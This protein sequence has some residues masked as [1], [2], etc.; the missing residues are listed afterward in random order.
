[1]AHFSKIKNNKVV[2]LIVIAN[3]DCGGGNF[4]DSEPIGQEFIASLSKSDPRLEGTWVQTSY[5]TYEGLH[6]PSDLISYTIDDNGKIIRSGGKKEGA[7]R[8]NFGQVGCTFDPN[9]GE[10]GEFYLP[11]D[12]K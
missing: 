11:E 2:D 7:F 10:Y 5:N 8:L 3:E 1:M 9:A 12:N 4:P 6:Y